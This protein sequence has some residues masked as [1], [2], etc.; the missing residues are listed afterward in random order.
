MTIDLITQCRF[1][2]NSRRALAAQSRRQWHPI[3]NLL[4]G[5]E[6][7]FVGSGDVAGSGVTGVNLQAVTQPS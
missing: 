7:L 3:D 4:C 6:E 5:F 2:A 1:F